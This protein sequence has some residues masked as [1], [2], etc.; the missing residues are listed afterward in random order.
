MKDSTQNFEK[1]ETSHY[2][3]VFFANSRRVL[4]LNKIE[5]LSDGC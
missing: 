5:E 1:M 3:K 4:K 2:G